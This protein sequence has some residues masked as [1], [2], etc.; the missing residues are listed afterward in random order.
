MKQIRHIALIAALAFPGFA[1]DA[2]AQAISNVLIPPQTLLGNLQGTSS[3]ASAVRFCD[4]ADA[5]NK[6][7]YLIAFAPLNCVSLIPPTLTPGNAVVWGSL[8]T[9]SIVVDAGAP[10]LLVGGPLGIPSSGTATNLTGTATGLTAGGFSA[11]NASNLS[12]GI[13]P[14]ART[15]GHMNGEPGTGSAAVGE[16]GE[17]MEA[18]V[19]SGSAVALTSGAAKTVTSITL[20]AGDWDVSGQVAFGSTGTTSFTIIAGSLSTTTDTSSSTLG[21]WNQTVSAAFVPGG[22]PVSTV[23][24]PSRFSISGPTQVFLVAFASFTVST[25]GAYGIIRARR[26]R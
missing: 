26:A 23:I 19:A 4:V 8:P 12:S 18:T 11:G 24:T 7:G 6:T 20:T 21:R 16:V 25:S 22:V 17:Y 3:G 15:N 13:L 5:L 2:L 1:N 10:P 9:P 14:A